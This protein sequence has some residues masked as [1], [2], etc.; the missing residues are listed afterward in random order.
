MVLVV[1]ICFFRD[2]F[3]TPLEFYARSATNSESMP[4]DRDFFV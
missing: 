3:K 4:I 1:T 2:K